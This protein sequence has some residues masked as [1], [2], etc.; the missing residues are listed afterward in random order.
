[1]SWIG[2]QSG[3][4]SSSHMPLCLTKSYYR[5]KFDLMFNLHSLML[6]AVQLSLA[7]SVSSQKF[8]LGIHVVNCNMYHDCRCK[9]LALL[10]LK[11]K[12]G[13]HCMGK[14]NLFLGGATSSQK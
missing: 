2:I 7:F 10:T 3:V 13:S 12:L 11:D 9:N 6:N 1:M 8:Y 4:I 14:A 5:E